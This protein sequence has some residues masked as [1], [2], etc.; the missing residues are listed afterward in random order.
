[1]PT[2]NRMIKKSL[3]L[4]KNQL[5][6]KSAKKKKKSNTK[7]IFFSEPKQWTNHQGGAP[8]WFSRSPVRSPDVSDKIF[9]KN[10]KLNE[11]MIKKLIEEINR[12]NVKGIDEHQV[13]EIFPGTP[14]RTNN[15]KEY[16][17]A[18]K[19][20]KYFHLYLSSKILTKESLGDYNNAIRKGLVPDLVPL[21]TEQYNKLSRSEGVK[22]DDKINEII[23]RLGRQPSDNEISY[24]LLFKRDPSGLGSD[25]I[26]SKCRD[27]DVET[28]EKIIE[29]IQTE[30]QERTHN[31]YTEPWRSK[32]TIAPSDVKDKRGYLTTEADNG[33]VIIDS[34]WDEFDDM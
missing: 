5:K 11:D 12:R 17:K 10:D 29:I 33:K 4:R 25:N 23:Y 8:F 26:I 24:G 31:P 22:Y 15:Y 7:K 18:R 32:L 2:K 34:D 13:I 3:R 19:L 9:F 14:P 20:A 21:G 30:I 6:R 16:E 28:D 27:V 1:M